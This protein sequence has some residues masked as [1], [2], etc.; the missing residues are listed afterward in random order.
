M[1]NEEK[2]SSSKVSIELKSGLNVELDTNSPNIEKLIATIVENKEAISPVD[3]KVECD[4]EKFDCASFR[5]IVQ[6]AIADLI[7]DITI[8]EDAVKAA[9]EW[10]SRRTADEGEEKESQVREVSESE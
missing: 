8:E 6:K 4:D 10:I 2:A 9:Q 7:K 3:I 5:E 1:A